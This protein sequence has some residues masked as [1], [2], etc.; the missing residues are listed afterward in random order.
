MLFLKPLGTFLNMRLPAPIVNGFCAGTAAFP[1]ILSAVFPSGYIPMTVK[2][3]WIKRGGNNL[4]LR[5]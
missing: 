2:S 4:C 3:L 5:Y 1:Q